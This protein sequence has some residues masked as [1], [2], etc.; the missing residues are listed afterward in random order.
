MNRQQMIDLAEQI[1]SGEERPKVTPP[2][3]PQAITSTLQVPTSIGD[4]R[5]LLHSPIDAADILPGFISF[6]GGGF[7]T[8]TPEMDKPWNLFLAETVNCHVF[9]IEYPLAP[10]HP[11]PIPVHV[12]YEVVQWIF[13]HADTLHLDAARIAIGGH[14]A[15][16]NL[17]T[18][19][20]LWN[21]EQTHPVPLIAQILDYPPLD[22]ATDPADKPFFEEAIPTEQARQFNA[23]YIARAEDAYHHLASPLYAAQ[24]EALPRT[25]ILT[26]EHDSLAQE[27]Q[28]YANRLQAAGVHV[29]HQEFAGQPHAFTHHGDANVALQAWQRIADFLRHVFQS[30][31]RS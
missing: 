26:A 9:N 7:I 30:A 22:L 14:S 27:A 11:F 21:A 12:T 29:V 15:G 8:G 24:L 19:I 2:Q 31:K 25:L 1:R 6:H 10:E 5:V 23:M 18:A 13:Q 16:G 4:V 20:S 17:A 3:P 28:Q